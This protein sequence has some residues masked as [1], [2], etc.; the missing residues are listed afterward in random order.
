MKNFKL[1]VIAFALLIAGNTAMAQNKVGYI[2][3]DNMVAIMPETAKLDRNDP[4]WYG[5]PKEVIRTLLGEP[6]SL[7]FS[8]LLKQVSGRPVF[9][10]NKKFS[11]LAGLT[12]LKKSSTMHSI[13]SEEFDKLS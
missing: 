12:P 9:I 1:L 10:G 11:S 4:S 6:K 3:L 8:E 2:S 5:F 13:L 7:P